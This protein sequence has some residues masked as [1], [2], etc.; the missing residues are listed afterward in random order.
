MIGFAGKYW[1]K[2]K[3]KESLFFSKSDKREEIMGLSRIRVKVFFVMT[4]LLM[5]G[6]CNV[7]PSMTYLKKD[8]TNK[9]HSTSQLCFNP[10]DVAKLTLETIHAG[11]LK[12]QLET[13]KGSIGNREIFVYAK[14]YKN[15]EFL[16]YQTISQAEHMTSYHD[17][18][19]QNPNLFTDTMG[20]DH[21]QI[22]LK[23]FEIDGLLLARFMR[24]FHKADPQIFEA[25]F[26][27]G[28][29]MM[30]GVKSIINGI[31]DVVFAVTGRTLD[32]WTSLVGS[33]KVLEHSI[34]LVNATTKTCT[35]V[36]G[37]QTYH[38]QGGDYYISG[39]KSDEASIYGDAKTKYD[40]LA[41]VDPKFPFVVFT[42]QVLK[43][44]P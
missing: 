10:G 35:A 34:Y 11:P 12:E 41:N 16:K 24:Q 39:I 42:A 29:T 44:Q 6:G 19:I 15:G 21:Y 25:T 28:D 33:E 20:K 26:S 13:A 43:P 8:G 32:D 40:T 37:E 5:F 2:V 17:L 22:T 3:I 1:L 9:T 18:V 30:M 36:A 14:I 4:V 38:I 7:G 27:P 31:F 23:V